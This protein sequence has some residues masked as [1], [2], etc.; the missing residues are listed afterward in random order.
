MERLLREAPSHFSIHPAA[1]EWIGEYLHHNEPAYDTIVQPRRVDCG[2]Y[3][4]SRWS[5]TADADTA[6]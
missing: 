2:Y 5:C 4:C 3:L 6:G 1:V